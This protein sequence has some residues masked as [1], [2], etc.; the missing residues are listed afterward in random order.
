MVI[1]FASF[2]VLLILH[3]LYVNYTLRKDLENLESTF[4]AKIDEVNFLM[5]TIYKNQERQTL[6]DI[7]KQKQ[8][9]FIRKKPSL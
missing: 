6:A 8:K 5:N 9:T 7:I 1:Y 3:L 2:L 4:T